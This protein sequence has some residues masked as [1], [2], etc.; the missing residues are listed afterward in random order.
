MFMIVVNEGTVGKIRVSREE[1]KRGFM[2]LP[3]CQNTKAKE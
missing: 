1:G 3:F 2:D